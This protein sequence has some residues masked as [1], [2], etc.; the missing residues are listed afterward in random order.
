M[1]NKKALELLKEIRLHAPRVL[2]M[3][4][5]MLDRYVFG[6]VH[7][8]S[9]EA[10]VPILNFKMNKDVLGGAGNVAH[11]LVNFG[12][13]TSVATLSGND[14]SGKSVLGLLQNIG[15]STDLFFKIEDL[16]TTTKTRFLSEGTHLLRVDKDSTGLPNIGYKNYSDIILKNLKEFDCLIISDYD[17]GFCESV[18]LQD[19][20]ERAKKNNIPVF[21]DPKGKKWNKYKNATCLTPNI[22]EVENKLGIRLVTELDFELSAKKIFNELN[23]ES[24]LITRGADGMTYYDGEKMLHHKVEKKEV[25]DVSGAG[26]TVIACLAS[27]LLAGISIHNSIELSGH[28]ASTVVS[29]IGTTPFEVDFLDLEIK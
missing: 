7:R 25:Y 20:I 5:I 15:V 3:G 29:H 4:D 2:V 18:K 13:K 24:I 19:I 21:V 12:N 10:P 9:P 28:I 11:N 6:D 27:S 22:K 16:N 1:Q 8:V 14:L 17:K 23:L 26:D